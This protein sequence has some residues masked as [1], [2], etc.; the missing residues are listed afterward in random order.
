MKAT[1]FRLI[2]LERA[3]GKLTPVHRTFRPLGQTVFAWSPR[4]Q[5]DL[6]LPP[7][8]EGRQAIQFLSVDGGGTKNRR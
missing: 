5:A 8:T 4:F 2:L 1:G 7:K 3:T 6:F